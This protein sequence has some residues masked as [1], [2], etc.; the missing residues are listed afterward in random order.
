MRDLMAASA[1]GAF[2]FLPAD[3]GDDDDE[4]T[5]TSSSAI[6]HLDTSYVLP[7]VSDSMKIDQ[8]AVS[9]L[10]TRFSSDVVPSKLT[11]L[12][13]LGDGKC[14]L[15]AVS[16]FLMGVDYFDQELRDAMMKEVTE[17]KQ[18]YM[19]TIVKAHLIVYEED[20]DLDD[21]EKKREVAENLYKELVSS[22]KGEVRMKDWAGLDEAFVLANAIRRPII[23]YA[24]SGMSSEYG[25]GLMGVGGAF[26]P[27]RHDPR[28]CVSKSP[29]LLSWS[30]VGLHFCAVVHVNGWNESKERIKFPLV[31]PV[32]VK[33]ASLT[34]KT[35][36]PLSPE[37]VAAMERYV[38]YWE[39]IK[40]PPKVSAREGKSG[41]SAYDRF[42]SFNKPIPG[43][44]KTLNPEDRQWYD[45]VVPID[46]G[47]K[48]QYLAFNLG[49]NFLPQLST[50]IM[51]NCGTDMTKL[52]AAQE[53]VMLRLYYLSMTYTTCPVPG[54][55]TVPRLRD[56]VP[57]TLQPSIPSPNKDEN[58]LF[59]AE[60]IEGEP[61]IPVTVPCRF[62]E[63]PSD[64]A[65][66]EITELIMDTYQGEDCNNYMELLWS[67]TDLMKKTLLTPHPGPVTPD[68]PAVPGLQ[69]GTTLIKAL[70]YLRKLSFGQLDF[71][72]FLALHP[73][74]NWFFCNSVSRWLKIPKKSDP[75]CMHLA[76][77]R[78]MANV[79]STS[80]VSEGDDEFLSDIMSHLYER[81]DF[82][83]YIREACKSTSS[84]LLLALSVLFLNTSVIGYF[85]PFNV[86]VAQQYPRLLLSSLRLKNKQLLRNVLL[87]MATLI[88]NDQL[89]S[90]VF[91]NCPPLKTLLEQAEKFSPEDASYAV[92]CSSCFS[93]LA[94]M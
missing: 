58:L 61:R 6:L 40:E 82:M 72:R 52:R 65:I 31:H 53:Y 25:E 32:L 28:S 85:S 37:E 3:D 47:S 2:S 67:L 63:E 50:I 69:Y 83:D 15:H 9:L 55:K 13:T 78:F 54:K 76:F 36:E 8:F 34:I 71:F 56:Y 18:F 30:R 66:A 79:L 19:D 51:L 93:E 35:S 29:I 1:T 91:T 12:V 87:G 10:S 59:L 81:S 43:F 42:Q 57:T 38:D 75:F 92:F 60:S 90:S 89:A 22:C 4:M 21:E 62:M 14:F 5:D 80:M 39:P 20:K 84:D 68:F 49:D 44:P 27:L 23:L 73:Y 46:F 64:R 26:L 45:I 86:F 11:P 33:G 24:D 16:L 17:N 41:P 70:T 88:C 77:I 74:Y 48:V 7:S 94:L